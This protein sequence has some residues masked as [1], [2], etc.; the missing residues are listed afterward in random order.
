[1]LTRNIRSSRVVSALWHSMNIS[2]LLSEEETLTHPGQHAEAQRTSNL[3]LA[4]PAPLH[5]SA[6]LSLFS[7]RCSPH[8]SQ[9]CPAHSPTFA[10]LPAP[11]RSPVEPFERKT[12]PW[13]TEELRVLVC[14]LFNFI[15][16]E[17]PNSKKGKWKEVRR[18]L[19]AAGFSRSIDACRKCYKRVLE[20][21]DE[22]LRGTPEMVLLISLKQRDTAKQQAEV[23]EVTERPTESPAVEEAIAEGATKKEISGDEGETSFWGDKL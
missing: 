1:M 18:S 5:S 7:P 14:A 12:Q 23:P 4:H 19:S 22:P 9:T 8:I 2:T 13:R 16:P 15:S 17:A 21:G 11:P 6:R 3:E 10:T 20:G